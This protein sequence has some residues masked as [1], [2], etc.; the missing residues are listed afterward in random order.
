MSV[1]I[2]AKIKFYQ[3]QTNFLEHAKLTKFSQ[4]ISKFSVDHGINAAS[5]GGNILSERAKRVELETD[6]RFCKR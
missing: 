4:Q 1:E 3:N 6:C 5:D 2:V